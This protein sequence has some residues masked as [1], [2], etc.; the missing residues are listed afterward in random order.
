[1]KVYILTEADF[2]ILD[3]RINMEKMK[4]DGHY[5]N[6]KIT[7]EV[8]AAHRKFNYIIQMWIQDMKK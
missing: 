4:S 6:E 8:E 5:S 3:N 7:P 2:E 1:M